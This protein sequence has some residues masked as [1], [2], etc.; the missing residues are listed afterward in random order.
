MNY[1]PAKSNK[2]D[3]FDEYQ[4]KTTLNM[5]QIHSYSS[6]VEEKRELKKHRYKIVDKTESFPK[7]MLV[8]LPSTYEK[9]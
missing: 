8:I 4:L 1:H 5:G 6:V 7:D 2:W 9:R 3:L